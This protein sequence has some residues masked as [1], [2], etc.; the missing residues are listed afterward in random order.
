MR[1]YPNMSYCM[2]ENTSLAL[3][4]IREH[5]EEEESFKELLDNASSIQERTAMK[6]LRL[7]LETLVELIDDLTYADEEDED[8]DVLNEFVVKDDEIVPA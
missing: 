3:R 1:N 4:Q 6:G 8:E 2:F 7:Q 5:L